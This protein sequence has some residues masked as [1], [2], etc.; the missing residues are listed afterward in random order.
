MT[1]LHDLVDTG[2]LISV[3][4]IILLVLVCI[5]WTIIGVWTLTKLALYVAGTTVFSLT[6][7]HFWIQKAR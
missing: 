3:S 4:L 5:P 2:M 6:M 7:L 1:I